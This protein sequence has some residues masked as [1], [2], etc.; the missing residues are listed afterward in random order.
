MTQLEVI[1]DFCGTLA[2]STLSRKCSNGIPPLQGGSCCYWVLAC[3]ANR[4]SIIMQDSLTSRQQAGLACHGTPNA[5]VC[6]VGRLLFGRGVRRASA[7]QRPRLH[8]SPSC[9]HYLFFFVR[10]F[11]RVTRVHGPRGIIEI[12]YFV[13]S[14][15]ITPSPPPRDAA[16]HPPMAFL[17]LS[18]L[19][20]LSIMFASLDLPTQCHILYMV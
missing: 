13:T 9:H 6:G 7:L 12:T 3:C 8:H 14:D 17:P 10:V 4:I 5:C 1:G 2:G 19:T 20:H 18:H 16:P 11:F 15:S